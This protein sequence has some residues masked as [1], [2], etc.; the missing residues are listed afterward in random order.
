MR[1]DF[2]LIVW[3]DITGCFDPSVCDVA[4]APEEGADMPAKSAKSLLPLAATDAGEGAAAAG[5]G[6][7]KLNPDTAGAGAGGF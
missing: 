2:W 4:G 6:A 1:F 5:G 7:I 3:L